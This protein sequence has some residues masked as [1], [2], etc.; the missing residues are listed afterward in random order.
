[1][2]AIAGQVF[3]SA[4]VFWRYLI[5][6]LL[7]PPGSLFLL[8]LAGLLLWRCRPRLG[9]GLVAAGAL[10]L[11][12]MGSPWLV[13]DLAALVERE[14]ALAQTQWPA[15][16]SQAGAI[17]VLGAGQ[18]PADPGWG[19]AQPSLMA[20]ERLRYGVRL[21]R[22]S[23]LPLLVT[24]GRPQ[25]EPQSEAELFQQVL[26][27]D[28]ALS[29]RWLEK[30]SNTT[31]ENALYSARLLKAEGI[32][33]IVLV[34]HA[35]H[36][37]RARWCFEQQGLEVIAAPMSFLST[38]PEG[39]LGGKAARH[40]PERAGDTR[41]ERPTQRQELPRHAPLAQPEV[42]RGGEDPLPLH[43]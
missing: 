7:L 20:L 27:R 2:A 30:Q 24:G 17:V 31:W 5:K 15:L 36:M 38:R 22:A 42:H 33:R 23:G 37:P 41:P 29:A 21:Q 11:W 18:T 1:M 19:G 39:L 14:P 40:R 13:H 25:G 26:Q 9:R 8:L 10:G 12:L 34:T 4:A 43:L 16:G 6:G 3:G 32:R 28:F 35:S